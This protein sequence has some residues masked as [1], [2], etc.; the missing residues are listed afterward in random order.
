MKNLILLIIVV[1]LFAC[2]QKR[3]PVIKRDSVTIGDIVSDSTI[4]WST[5]GTG[6][7]LTLKGGWTYL[8]ATEPCS[9]IS[10]PIIVTT[11][12]PTNL[13]HC[14][15]CAQEIKLGE[16]FAYVIR[17]VVGDQKYGDYIHIRCAIERIK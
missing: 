9:L 5:T 10:W 17:K 15:H 13:M 2:A 8:R 16:S 1:P 11:L 12:C 14:T 4:H 3:E 6:D 7:T